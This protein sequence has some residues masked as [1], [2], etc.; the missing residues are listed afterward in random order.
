[1]NWQKADTVNIFRK[2][3]NSL[4]IKRITVVIILLSNL[5]FPNVSAQSKIEIFADV[6]GNDT[7][8]KLVNTFTD[9]LKR[10]VPASFVVRPASQYMGKGIYLGNTTIA[11]QPVK[12]SSKLL[13]AGVEAFSGET[14]S[15]TI[16]I[17]GNSN[18]AIGHG[19]FT[20]LDMI[21]YR[22]YF[23]NADW[24]IIPGK[25]NLFP[26]W[27]IVSKPSFDH[28]RIWYGY[29]TGSKLADD[30]YNFW[31]LANRQG[32]SINAY[33]GHAYEEIISRNREAFL[34][35]PEWMYPQP[36]KGTILPND[37]KFDVSQEGLIQLLI[38]DF[39]KR[40]QASL[41]NKTNDY[42]MLSLAPS[43]G[44]GT[45]NTPACQKL[46]SITDRVYY[47]VNR[48]AKAIQKKYPSTYIGCLAYGEYSPPPG[49][50]V[51]PNVFVGIT[52]AFNASKYSTE[53]LVVEWRKKG[54]FIGIYD[55]FSWYA[56]DFDIPGQSLAS[57]TTDIVKT[58]K[59]YYDKGVRAYEAE[60]SIGWISKG[61]GYYLAAK[62]MWDAKTDA[63]P[64][65]KEFFQLCFGK[66][67]EVMKKLWQEWEDYSFANVR[68]QDLA[69]WIDYII[70]AEQLEQSAGFKKRSYQVKSYLHYLSLYSNYM[71]TR[72]ENDLK[73]L[74][75]YGYRKL[76]DGSVPGYPA[77]FV[78]GGASGIKDMGFTDNAKWRYNNTPV[79]TEEISRMLLDDR[80][81]I[82]IVSNVRQFTTPTKFITIPNINKYKQLFAD[83]AQAD[84]AIWLTSEW[85]FE[86]KNKGSGNYIDFAGDF[87]ADPTVTR[88]IKISVYP[89]SADG[90]VSEESRLFYYE[91]TKTKVPE[92]IGLSQFAAGYYTMIIEDPTK[93]FRL[94]FP[95]SMNYSIVLRPKRQ[96]STPAFFH[97]FLYVPEGTKKFNI[98]KSSTLE[99]LTPAG[100][101][102][103]FGKDKPEDVQVD[104]QNGE[105]GLWR[106][107]LVTNKLYVEGIPP[108]LG[109][110][111]TQM[112][113]P[114]DAK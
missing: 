26:K 45:C 15:N 69:R 75:N 76:D 46:G 52:T 5:F 90:N 29:G 7:L 63:E 113:I 102:V 1:M 19:I 72:S 84:N 2:Q 36:A 111:A 92:K 3:Q 31:F 109:L 39:E 65:K 66:A 68:E 50:N 6:Q 14:N 9:Q 13:Q 77:F 59:K 21:G 55:Y 78:I 73:L 17:I 80:R 49:K 53:Q 112:M 18:M 100:R 62:I 61:L 81:K 25:P 101:I 41:K 42:K 57:R 47:L 58:V 20:Y 11:N 98:I 103:T 8:Q 89:Y 27:S 40:I 54:A 70:S 96:V 82:K 99:L 71:L 105:A 44:T 83:S 34:Q 16:Q 91:Y 64:L 43:D 106:I 28:R 10:S 86:I 30:D 51:E 85:V 95:S 114:A 93:I 48:I 88:P 35:H 4:V 87:I 107:K 22:F 97:A 94:K 60:S 24:H 67:A 23:A 33:F 74:L 32:G 104:V 56:W 38:S 110:S 12:P 37:T 108:Y 79:T